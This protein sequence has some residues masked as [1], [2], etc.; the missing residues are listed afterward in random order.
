MFNTNTYPAYVSEDHVDEILG[1][2]TDVS[3]NAYYWQQ[4]HADV[5]KQLNSLHS[6]LNDFVRDN[7]GTTDAHAILE[8]L[9]EQFA[10]D[11]EREVTAR[12]TITVNVVAN[13]PYTMSI[14]EVSQALADLNVEIESW[15]TDLDISTDVADIY[16]E[17]LQEQ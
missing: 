9:C 2:M 6:E 3:D 8:A 1:I 15:N 16:V 10:L 12:L 11:A 4:R 7:S 5:A 17:D 14:D 13:A